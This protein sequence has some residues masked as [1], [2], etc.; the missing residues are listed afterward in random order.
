[1]GRFMYVHFGYDVPR[2]IEKE[3]NKL[4]DFHFKGTTASDLR[5]VLGDDRIGITE[6]KLPQLKK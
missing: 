5:I 6:V 3:Y 1:M 2:N 4:L